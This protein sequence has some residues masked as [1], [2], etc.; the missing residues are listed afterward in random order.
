MSMRSVCLMWSVMLS[1]LL[2]SPLALAQDWVIDVR[3]PEEV[4]AGKVDGAVNI[5][6]QNIV[7]GVQQLGVKKEDAI[8]VYCR[9]GRRSSAHRFRADWRTAAEALSCRRARR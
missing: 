9:S 5:E 2:F 6:Y 7:A 1:T 3:T 8:F 4:A